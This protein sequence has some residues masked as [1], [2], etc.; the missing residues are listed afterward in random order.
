MVVF[1]AVEEVGMQPGAALCG[2]FP[3]STLSFLGNGRQ[4]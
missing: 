4:Q 3:S 2:F 1:R